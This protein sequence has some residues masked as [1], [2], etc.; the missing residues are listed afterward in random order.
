LKPIAKLTAMNT[1]IEGLND[2]IFD[3]YK[4]AGLFIDTMTGQGLSNKLVGQ[5]TGVR[6]RLPD[7]R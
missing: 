4:M 1:A 6:Y 2:R 5:K 3:Y 7:D